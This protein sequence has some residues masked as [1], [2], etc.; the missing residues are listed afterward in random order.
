MHQSSC[1]VAACLCAHAQQR[2]CH[3]SG[4]QAATN[5]SGR[6][7]HSCFGC[8]HV[9]VAPLLPCAAVLGFLVVC[10]VLGVLLWKHKH[11][12][13]NGNDAG[14]GSDKGSDGHAPDP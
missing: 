2:V 6:L 8:M 1:Q 7:A 3:A 11:C 14:S 13:A 12:W 5:I 9:F 4:K 10:C